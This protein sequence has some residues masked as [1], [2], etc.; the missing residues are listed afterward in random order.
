MQRNYFK[1]AY[2]NFVHNK[3]Y[4]FINLSGLVVGIASCLLITLHILEETSYD[5]FHPTPE[6]T[7]RVVMDMYN[8]NEFSTK[9]APVFAAVGPNMAQG[10]PEVTDFM[11]ILPFGS[12]VYSVKQ[13]DGSMVRFNE[14]RAVYA[15]HNFFKITG[16]KL[17]Q[18]N[19]DEVLAKKDQV[20]LSQSTARR[21]FGNENALGKTITHR[22][23]H[24]AVVSGIMEDFPENSH[25]QFDIISSLMSWDGYEEWPQNWGWYD[26]YTYVT[27]TEQADVDQF[28][29]KVGVYLDDKKAETYQR[30][31]TREVL[32]LQNMADIHL[33]SKGLSW[34]MGENGG[35]NQVYFLGAIAVLILVIA[36][37]NFIN[38]STARAVKRSK[39]VGIRK[40]VGARKSNLISQFLTEAFV[41]NAVAVM[42]GAAIVLLITPLVNRSLEISLQTA[43]LL[44]P[45]TI[46]GLVLVIVVGTLISGL[47]PSFILTSFKPLNVLKGKFYQRKR[48]FGFRQMLVV[49]QF[50]VSIVL[51]LGTLLVVRQLRF[52]QSQDLGLS[53]EQTLVLRAPTSSRGEN[54]LP[55]RKKVFYSKVT[56]LSGIKG[57]TASSIVP[58]AEN[59]NISGFFTQKT[60]NQKNCYIVSIDEHYLPDY[61]IEIMAGRNFMKELAGDSNAVIINK[62]AAELFE[63]NSPEESIG[64]LIN[65]GTEG[66]RKVVGVINNYHHSSLREALDPIMFMFRPNGRG[67]FY[68]IKL[69][70]QSIQHA[71]SQIETTWD[72]VYPDNPFDY[73]FLDEFFDR[74]YKSDAQFNTVF[75]GFAGLAIFVACLGLFG[76]ISFTAEQSRR[77][78]GIRKVLGASIAKV[79][80]LL[81][82]DYAM[83]ILVSI[84][85]AFPLGYYLMSQWLQD[86]AYK[87]S[88]DVSIFVIGA[89]A[90]TLIACFTVSFKSF[91]AAN[92]NPA[93]TLREE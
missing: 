23:E 92:T 42:L 91:F 19:P 15:D 89:A 32:W 46:T 25:L 72:E 21:Y 74:Q 47:Y 10:F 79:V 20:V 90:I 84:V 44:S 36:W 22:G 86:F 71:M 45:E 3:S 69:E 16:F 65:P 1:S 12:G 33:Y 29:Q 35:A 6:H 68:S 85:V 14:N 88:I 78:I 76:L 58:G 49:F 5:N 60:Q 82:K 53:V 40:V 31:G 57:F 18:G 43:L 24:E 30:R 37:V 81:I 64:E 27:L 28:A 26:F 50:T 41:Y 80:I 61:E 54:D 66:E 7:Y 11:R 56:Q 87:T 59:F 48:K 75:I 83:L 73:F 4:S 8:N 93:D 70:G 51:I 62:R 2:R 9:S 17:L 63:F 13:E 38:L 77:E 67:N 52:M 39:E 34:E 55:E